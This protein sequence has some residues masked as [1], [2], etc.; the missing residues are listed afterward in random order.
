[1]S[2][3]SCKRKRGSSPKGD[4]NASDS[5]WEKFMRFITS[6][7]EL[8]KLPKATLLEL[9]NSLDVF[10]AKSSDKNTIVTKL[11]EYFKSQKSSLE[12]NP[13][14]VPRNWM[15]VY[16][17]YETAG[18]AKKKRKQQKY[19]PFESDEY[20]NDEGSCNLSVD[21]YYKGYRLKT[22][23]V[24]KAGGD[25]TVYEVCDMS[26]DCNY[27][28]KKAD[29]DSPIDLELEAKWQRRS[30]RL[31]L[32]PK[33][34][35]AWKCESEDDEDNNYIISKKLDERLNDKL[36]TIKFDQ[37]IDQK[38]KR[39]KSHNLAKRVLGAILMLHQ[40]ARLSHGD[41]HDTNIMFDKQGNIF[42]IDFGNSEPLDEVEEPLHD[43]LVDYGYFTG[44]ENDTVYNRDPIEYRDLIHD[45]IEKYM[46]EK[47]WHESDV[48]KVLQAEK[49][50]MGR[51]L[52]TPYE[53]LLQKKLLEK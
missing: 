50:V 21:S 37:N 52:E 32:A 30:H 40:N 24:F 14:L 46:D 48:K 19:V 27:V 53:M 1:M 31:G 36:N 13:N 41:I 16:C 17:A 35:L 43:L 44:E 42:L 20:L 49:Y 23:E 51:F 25:A 34:Y 7:D 29:H 12:A 2:A 8:E 26:N 5:E 4:Y 10:V 38:E 28:V 3:E 22:G 15:T 18:L 39:E 9:F 47:D 6:R 11:L 45:G 33:V